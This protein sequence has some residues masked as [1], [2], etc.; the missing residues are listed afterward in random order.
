MV[1]LEYQNIKTFL[2]KVT[3]V[4]NTVPQTYVISDLNGEEIGETFYKKSLQ[5]ANQKEFR[6]EK[7]IGYNKRL[8]LKGYNNLLIVGL[9]K[10]TQYK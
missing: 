9:I 1:I 5:K 2:K 10:K 8:K 3:L 7:V 6:V 4:K